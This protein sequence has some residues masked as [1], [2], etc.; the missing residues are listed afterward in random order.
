MGYAFQVAS[1]ASTLLFS[2]KIRVQHYKYH[3]TE[4]TFFSVTITET[5][6]FY[7]GKKRKKC[8]LFSLDVFRQNISTTG[9]TKATHVRMYP[10]IDRLIAWPLIM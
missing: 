7:I 3:E 4:L 1:W 6:L 9:T 5:R 2:D 8:V 10:M